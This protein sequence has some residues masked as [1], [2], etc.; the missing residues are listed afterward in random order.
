MPTGAALVL[1]ARRE[2]NSFLGNLRALARRFVRRARARRRFVTLGL[3]EPNSRT[4][5]IGIDEVDAG[6]LEGPPDDIQSGV[7][8]FA[9]ADL[10]LV[11]RHDAYVGFGRKLLL[12]PSQ[13]APRGP[14]LCWR[15]HLTDMPEAYFFYNYE[16]L[17]DSV[18]CIDILFMH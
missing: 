4:T 8:R 15:Q 10:Q 11:N 9:Y 14:A 1:T 13:E 5:S 3:S 16:D 2:N 18:N 6:C 17:L 12:R 7:S